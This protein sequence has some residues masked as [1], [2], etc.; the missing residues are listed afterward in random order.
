[1]ELV[2][3]RVDEVEN[4]EL[5]VLEEVVVVVVKNSHSPPKVKI[6]LP[7]VPQIEV[8]IKNYLAAYKT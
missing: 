5:V 7:S 1:V 2:V 8:F 6:R 4:V 3:L